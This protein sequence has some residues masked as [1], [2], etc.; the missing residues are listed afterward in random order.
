MPIDCDVHSRGTKAATVVAALLF[1]LCS[2]SGVEGNVVCPQLLWSDEFN[3]TSLDE[4]NWVHQLGDGCSE[5]VC[6]WG[7]NELQVYQTENTQVSDGYLTITARRE[8]QTYTSSRIRSIN[9][10]SFQYGL[11]EAR[12]QIPQASQGV[13]PA[14]WMLGDNFED[15]GWPLCGEID[16]MENIG[17]EPQTV[18]G[19]I[20]YGL[21]FPQ[22]QFSGNSYCSPG[23]DFAEDF[24]IFAVEKTPNKIRW[25]VDGVVYFEREPGDLSPYEWPFEQNYHFLLNVAV[26][27]NFPGNPDFGSRFPVAMK[28]DYVRVFDSS[29]GELSGPNRVSFGETGVVFEVLNPSPAYDSFSWIVPSGAQIASGQ[30]STRITIDFGT[31]I[32][33]GL[34]S[35]EATSSACVAD[36]R[37]FQMYVVIENIQQTTLFLNGGDTNESAEVTLKTG[38]MT[39]PAPNPQIQC[40]FVSRNTVQYRRNNGA[41]YDTILLSTDA[42]N[43]P[44]LFLPG[45][46][47]VFQMDVFSSTANPGT[48]ILLQ[49]EN[50]NV[51]SGGN[52]P[53]GRHSRFV[54]TLNGEKGE[55]QT[56]TFDFLDRPSQQETTVNQIALL[57]ASNS[58]TNDV[59]YIDNFAAYKVI[60]IPQGAVTEMPSPSPNITVENDSDQGDD[61]DDETSGV[62]VTSQGWF[63]LVGIGMLLTTFIILQ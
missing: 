44:I 58:F 3:G 11:F 9:L 19:T 31:T 61:D 46:D 42:L 48:E 35:V 49:L 38:T 53:N 20:H 34:V 8:Q 41:Q 57:F 32:G 29:L 47:H 10:Q 27:G 13:W 39:N 60:P 5:G 36:K 30:G 22:N 14:F 23:I 17:R 12:I 56:I 54:G 63:Q 26:G 4:T 28:V 2:F 43:D 45:G 62:E 21:A 51:A 18:H 59:Y 24:H 33:S 7:N 37:S 16:I 25:L 40:P 6:G 55:W 15:V 50:S 52:Y 1:D